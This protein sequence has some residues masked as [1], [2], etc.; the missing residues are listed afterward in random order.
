MT[1]AM[2]LDLFRLIPHEELYQRPATRPVV[3]I[4]SQLPASHDTYRD[5]ADDAFTSFLVN[6]DDP[7]VESY[8]RL[9]DIFTILL[10]EDGRTLTAC[11]RLAERANAKPAYSVFGVNALGALV[12]YTRRGRALPSPKNLLIAKLRPMEENDEL[13]HNARE[14][15]KMLSRAYP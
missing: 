4:I 7:D 9:V 15:L 13:S 5:I 3:S 6:R 2:L 1:L 10:Y 14:C 11:L 8:Q 12:N